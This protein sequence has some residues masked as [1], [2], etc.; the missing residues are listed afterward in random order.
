[1]SPKLILN[2]Q[3]PNPPKKPQSV[4]MW[5]GP[6]MTVV[7]LSVWRLSLYWTLGAPTSGAWAETR[8]NNNNNNSWDNCSG[9]RGKLLQL[10]EYSEM[11]AG[12]DKQC[13]VTR[14]AWKHVESGKTKMYCTKS[15]NFILKWWFWVWTWVRV[16]GFSHVCFSSWVFL[17]N[18]PVETINSSPGSSSYPFLIE[19]SL[20]NS[21]ANRVV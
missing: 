9:G 21:S 10:R 5:W 12:C 15:I 19:L 1:M 13:G 11:W 14:Q 18:L 7:V 4:L 16:F 17:C 8:D 3:F 2:S 20:V 6:G